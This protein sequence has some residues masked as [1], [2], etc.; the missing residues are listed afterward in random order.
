MRKCSKV[1]LIISMGTL[2]VMSS[3]AQD[4]D[5]VTDAVR[6]CNAKG[7][8]PL[9]NCP[10][11]N[12][13]IKQAQAVMGNAVNDPK[14]KAENKAAIDEAVDMAGVNKNN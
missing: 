12:E 14:I 2:F 11:Y 7:I 1:L 13:A 10:E 3:F 9:T 6:V 5:I 4:V 8:K